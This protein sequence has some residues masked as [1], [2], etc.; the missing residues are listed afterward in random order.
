MTKSKP[1]F[2]AL[3]TVATVLGTLIIA[4]PSHAEEDL[5]KEG[6]SIAFDVKKGNCLACHA[7]EGG[8]L[9]G[10][11]GPPLVNIKDRF[12]DKNQLKAQIADATVNNPNT[13]MPPFGK[14]NILSEDELAK[15][16]EFIYS[17]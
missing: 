3:S 11:I 14:N 5:K 2:L 15:V 1:F 6:K 13:I 7:V 4:Q 10:N 9:P 17:L 16:V 8:S 12:P